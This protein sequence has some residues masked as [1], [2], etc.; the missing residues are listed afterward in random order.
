MKFFVQNMKLPH[1]S[2]H[3]F[4]VAALLEYFNSSRDPLNVATS[5]FRKA[6][7]KFPKDSNLY[8]EYITFLYSIKDRQNA[9]S[10]FKSALGAL[11][12]DQ[13]RELWDTANDYKVI[14]ERSIANIISFSQERRDVLNEADFPMLSI[15][16][17]YKF[18]D[19]WPC[20]FATTET[21]RMHMVPM[22]KDKGKRGRSN[23]GAH[24]SGS[25]TSRYPMP[26]MSNMIQLQPEINELNAQSINTKNPYLNTIS[27]DNDRIFPMNATID[28]TRLFTIPPAIH[29]FINRLPTTSNFSK[30]PTKMLN[31]D[32]LFAKLIEI[33]PTNLSDRKRKFDHRDS[34]PEPPAKHRKVDSDAFI[35]SQKRTKKKRT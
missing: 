24:G 22:E 25:T 19:L 20:D 17:R 31:V 7:E 13:T 33:Q 16:H 30:D 34:D 32:R 27:L 35:E 28:D 9:E 4:V 12:P 18:K 14:N 29:S 1:A 6:L 26:Q 3:F 2:Y 11:I 21:Y 10:A 5:I 8:R 23:H 15:I